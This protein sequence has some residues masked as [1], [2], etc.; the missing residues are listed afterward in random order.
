MIVCGT[1]P[2]LQPVL[3][4]FRR[5]FSIVSSTLSQSSKSAST[6]PSGQ[7]AELSFVNRKQARLKIPEER[8]VVRTE[9][10]DQLV[11][12]IPVDSYEH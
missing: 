9:S 6:I 1:I 8:T 10:S 11:E 2:T 5:A 4:V 7:D 12:E 3:Q